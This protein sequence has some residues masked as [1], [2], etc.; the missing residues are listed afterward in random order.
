M[1]RKS[2]LDVLYGP[3]IVRLTSLHV[4]LT[5]LNSRTASEIMDTIPEMYYHM[6]LLSKRISRMSYRSEQLRSLS[7]FP[8][9]TASFPTLISMMEQY[10]NL[11]LM[12]VVQPSL[13]RTLSKTNQLDC[14]DTRVTSQCLLSTTEVS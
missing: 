3:S 9:T 7:T 13:S 4:A 14:P 6:M 11:N 2:N 8:V 12:L 10:P 1:A 5:P